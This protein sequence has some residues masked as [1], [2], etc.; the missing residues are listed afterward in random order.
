MQMA[1]CSFLAKRGKS[2]ALPNSG[3]Y[4]SP[5]GIVVYVSNVDEEWVLLAWL[6]FGVQ[7]VSI[8]AAELEAMAAAQAFVGTLLMQPKQWTR[9][10]QDWRP[11]GY[12]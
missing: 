6:C 7:A 2:L 4:A 1:V 10:F 11:H 8:T 3:A 5:K 9:I 12:L